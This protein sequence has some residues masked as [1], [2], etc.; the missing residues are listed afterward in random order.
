M[1]TASLTLSAALALFGALG[2]GAALRAEPIAVRIVERESGAA[3]DPGNG[4]EDAD[5]LELHFPDAEDS[6]D[7]GAKEAPERLAVDR[8]AL[9]PRTGQRE[10]SSLAARVE[11]SEP[12]VSAVVSAAVSAAAPMDDDW[13]WDREFKEAVRPF[14]DELD[15]AGIVDAVGGLRSYLALTISSAL[16]DGAPAEPAPWEASGNRSEARQRS[17]AQVEKEKMLASIMIEEM[18]ETVKPW[19]FSLVALYLLWRMVMLGLD[20]S[21]WKTT[22]ARKRAPRSRRRSA[23]HP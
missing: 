10:K 22:R 14:Y 5:R 8:Q 23:R 3:Q 15:A 19:L 16:D 9:K 17:A 7:D 12:S 4:Q 13:A 21:R 6:K 20:Y 11:V 1:R 18:I 2:D